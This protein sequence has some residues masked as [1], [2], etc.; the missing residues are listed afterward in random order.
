MRLKRYPRGT[1]L[2]DFRNSISRQFSTSVCSEI[3][4]IAFKPRFLGLDDTLRE[5]L[6]IYTFFC[7]ILYKWACSGN[8]FHMD[9]CQYSESTGS[10]HY[11]HQICWFV[12]DHCHVVW[13]NLCCLSDDLTF[14]FRTLCY[15]QEF[16]AAMCPGYVTTK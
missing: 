4:S 1:L 11:I 5:I 10:L 3:G 15:L 14:D 13:P 16:M 6:C 12:Y 7:E 8:I 9:I 2:Q